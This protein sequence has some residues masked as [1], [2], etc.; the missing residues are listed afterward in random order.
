MKRRRSYEKPSERRVRE[1]GEAVR[2]MKKA[3]RK[4]AQRE[5]LIAMPAKKKPEV[6]GR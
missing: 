6:R 4:L 5:G 2:R 1:K 3:A